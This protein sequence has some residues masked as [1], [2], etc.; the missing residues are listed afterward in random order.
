VY[1]IQYGQYLKPALRRAVVKLMGLTHVPVIWSTWKLSEV[2]SI[3]AQA[4]GRAWLNKDQEREGIVFK[5]V[6]GGMTF[7]AIS[8]KYL[9]GE[10]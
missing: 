4:E 1:N 6:D 2:D 7:K 10:K 9:L 3:L 8:N 5:Q